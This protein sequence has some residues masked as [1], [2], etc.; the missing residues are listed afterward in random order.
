MCQWCDHQGQRVITE[1]SLSVLCSSRSVCRCCDH[2]VQC[3]S[4]VIT[5]FSVSVLWSPSSVCQCC[6]HKVQCVSVLVAKLTQMHALWSP[7]SVCQ[8]YDHQVQCVIVV[9]TKF[10]VSVLWSRSI[11]QCCAHQVK[12]VSDVITKFSVSVLWSRSIYQCCAHQVKCVSDVITKFSV[13]VL[14]LFCPRFPRAE[15]GPLGNG[16]DHGQVLRTLHS[17]QQGVRLH[18]HCQVG[19]VRQDFQTI[20]RSFIRSWGGRRGSQFSCFSAMEMERAANTRPLLW[21]ST[22][23]TSLVRLE[24]SFEKSLSRKFRKTLED[25]NTKRAM[26]WDFVFVIEN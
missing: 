18:Q 14:W 12:C 21:T 9:N 23:Y 5:K 3:V 19:R 2:Q 13:S 25:E 11:Y 6:D 24:K 17:S 4:D 10:S 7:N 8:C 26:I 15:S 20:P 16:R 22:Q 1:F